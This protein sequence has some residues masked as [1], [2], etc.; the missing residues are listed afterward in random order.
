MGD[1]K[2]FI[3]IIIF[4]ISKNNNY[5]LSCKSDLKVT[6]CF[7]CSTCN[8]WPFFSKIVA[9]EAYLQGLHRSNWNRAKPVQTGSVSSVFF[10]FLFHGMVKL[11]L[12]VQFF[13]VQSGLSPV[14][15][16]FYGLDFWSLILFPWSVNCW[17]NLKE[18]TDLQN[19]TY[20]G[21]TII[22][23]SKKVISGKQLSKSIKGFINQL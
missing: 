8:S 23:K 21:D 17:T 2:Y 7:G 1:H 12:K 3:V 5:K 22:S 16:W 20:S 10:G 11:Q 4:Y 6:Y 19:W 14:F 9:N 15:F 13:P 18:L